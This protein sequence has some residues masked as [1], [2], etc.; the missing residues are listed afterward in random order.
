[1]IKIVLEDDRSLRLLQV[2]LD[3]HAPADMRAAYTDY[4]AHDVDLAQAIAQLSDVA[5]ALFPASVTLVADQAAL[6][7]ALPGTRV[8]MMETLRMGR[9]ELAVAPDLRVIQC[10]GAAKDGVDLAACEARGIAVRTQRRRTN[11]AVAEHAMALTMALAKQIPFINGLVT[12]QRL[13]ERHQP[14]RAYDTRHTPNANW[15]RVGG[16]RLLSEMTLGVLGLGEIGTEMARLAHGCGMQVLYHQRHRASTEAEQSVAASYRTLPELLAQSDAI[17]IHLPLNASTRI[18][19]DARALAQVKPGALLINTSRAEIVDYAALVA[20]LDSGQLAGAGLDVMHREPA[21][22]NDT[23]LD[24][25]NVILTPHLAG[26]SRHIRFQD[27]SEML[28]GVAAA[29]M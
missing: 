16:L 11:V 14:F 3:P 25:T 20:A 29:L 5:P 26:G 17:S 22:E 8:L 2:V 1:M 27:F 18:L 10:F 13:A 21:D 7:Q 4:M 12:P 6:R 9:E 23:L 24:R 15:A 19:L 28:A